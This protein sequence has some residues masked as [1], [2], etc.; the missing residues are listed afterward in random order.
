MLMRGL[1]PGQLT[2][3]I[4]TA[5]LVAAVLGLGLWALLRH[6]VPVWWPLQGDPL[7]GR[8]VDWQF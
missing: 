7:T 8:T 2:R 5:L 3:E 1:T 6:G 4:V